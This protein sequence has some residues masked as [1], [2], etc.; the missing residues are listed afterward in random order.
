MEPFHAPGERGADESGGP[1]TAHDRSLE[2]AAATMR[3]WGAR[4]TLLDRLRP[5][6]AGVFGSQRE[7]RAVLITILNEVAGAVSSAVSVD[8]VL[9]VIVDRAKLISDTD[10][11]VLILADEHGDGLDIDSMVVRGAMAQHP[12][13]EWQHHVENLGAH[14]PDAGDVVVMQLT[15]HGE[16]LMGCPIVSKG[17]LIGLLCAVNDAARPFTRVQQDYYSI[18][19]VLAGSAIENARFSEQSRNMLLASERDRIARE[20]HDGVVQSL[21]SISLGLEVCKRQVYHD[22]AACASRLD[23]LQQHLNLSMTELRRFVYALRPA[24]LAELGLV[25]ATENWVREVTL[26]RAVRGA[27]F[28]EGDPP[29]LTP[30][31]EACLY[32]VIKEAVSNV[33]RHSGAD[34]FE[35]RIGFEPGL[36]RVDVVDNGNGFDVSAVSECSTEQIGI[37]SIRQRVD[38]EG[39]QFTIA[40]GSGEGTK[41]TA[42]IPVEGRQP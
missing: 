26:G 16:W 20:M 34:S 32:R 2:A 3:A 42:E 30:S 28:V 8:E 7:L 12:Q 5:D 6:G 23:E 29:Q 31:Q 10:K 17:H 35:V 41:V 33:V 18:L 1:V 36:A 4:R 9:D 13:P 15:E 22:Q 38:R 19:A 25:G 37:R 27:V 24:K 11:A 39:G 21:F 40:C 14:L